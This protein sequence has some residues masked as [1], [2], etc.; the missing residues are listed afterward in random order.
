MFDVRSAAAGGEPIYDGSRQQGP[1]TGL[2]LNSSLTEL[3][4]ALATREVHPFGWAYK[5]GHQFERRTLEPRGRSEDP[6]HGREVVRDGVALSRRHSQAAW[7]VFASASLD[8]HISLPSLDPGETHP[9]RT[10]VWRNHL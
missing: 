4:R 9:I 8:C 6:R 2:L 3:T 10:P 5:H 1:S 7:V